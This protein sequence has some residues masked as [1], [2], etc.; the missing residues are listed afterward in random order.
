[1]DEFKRTGWDK[2]VDHY[3]GKRCANYGYL[4]SDI[5]LALSCIYLCGGDHIEGVTTHLEKISY[6]STRS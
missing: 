5:L 3:L 6:H 1:M 4:Y 2:L